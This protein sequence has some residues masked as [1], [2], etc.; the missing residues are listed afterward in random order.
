MSVH[1]PLDGLAR[2]S[3]YLMLVAIIGLLAGAVEA[4]IWSAINAYHV[5]AALLQGEKYSTGVVGLLHMFDAFLVAAVLLVVAVGTYG[6]FISP[7]ADLPDVL[8]V[9]SLDELKARFVSVLVLLMTVT[10]VEHLMSW[11]DPWQSLVFAAAITVV[12]VTLVAYN[13]LGTHHQGGYQLP[14]T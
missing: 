10:F 1:A 14:R 9:R 11:S 13:R 12:S 8:V 3:R 2:K 7:L 5:F 6:L 4:C